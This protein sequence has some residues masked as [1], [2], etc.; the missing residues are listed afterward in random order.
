MKCTDSHGLDSCLF[1]QFVSV[2]PSVIFIRVH[3]WL[4]LF[5]ER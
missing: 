3:P 2:P 4:K 1:V 5:F